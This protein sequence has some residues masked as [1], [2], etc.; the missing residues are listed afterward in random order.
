[1]SFIN[2]ILMKVEN[3]QLLVQQWL[4]FFPTVKV[5]VN[6]QLFGYW[7]SSKCIILCASLYT[8]NS[9]VPSQIGLENRRS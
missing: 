4:T 6:Q 1:M 7:E 8:I 5:N 2:A 9:I 3:K